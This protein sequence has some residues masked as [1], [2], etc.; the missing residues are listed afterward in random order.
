MNNDK[1]RVAIFEQATASAKKKLTG[2][3]KAIKLLRE[4]RNERIQQR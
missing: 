4:R 3:N 1:A 2:F